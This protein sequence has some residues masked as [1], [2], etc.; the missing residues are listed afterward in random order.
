MYSQLETVYIL[1]IRITNIDL[2][3]LALVEIYIKIY[4]Q[5]NLNVVV[6]D[7]DSD[8]NK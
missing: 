2:F 1:T 6:I 3:R 5:R 4:S 7:I 8:A